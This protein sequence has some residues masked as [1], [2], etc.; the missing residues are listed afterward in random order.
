M[1]LTLITAPTVEPISLSL[2]KA[3]LRVSHSNDDDLIEFYIRAAREYC[4][5]PSGFLGRALVTQTWRLT[6]DEFPDN[7]IKIPLPPL[8]SVSSVVY[9]DSA[10]NEQT[11]DQ[12]SYFVDSASE[13][14]WIVPVDTWPT[15]LES[16]NV[17]R[18]DF[19]AGYAPDNSGSPIDYTAN[20]PANVRQAMMLL[21]GN[22]ME[23][24]EANI[25]DTINQIPFGVDI[26]L[27]RHKID[28]SMA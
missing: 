8:Q 18:I 20:I 6:L 7:E 15:P 12:D 10:G 3:Q 28:K 4:D 5:G 23:H 14:G 25:T 17:V 16:I 19:V 13:P 21:I 22:W 26:L 11:I 1:A 2:A 9:D 24:R 27:R